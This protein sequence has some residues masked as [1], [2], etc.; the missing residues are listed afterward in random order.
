MEAGSEQ[1][2]IV[3]AD[4]K[5]DGGLRILGGGEAPLR[6]LEKGEF[7]DAGDF[8][9]C[10]TEACAKAEKSAGLRLE[11]LYYNLDDAKIESVRPGGSRILDG[12]GEIQPADVRAAVHAAERI[13]GDF[14]KK[15]VYSTEIDYVIDGQDP[16]ADPVGIFGHKLDV[17]VHLLLARAGRWDVWDRLIRRA[18][19]RKS[20]AVLS[21][22]SSAYGVLSPEERRGKRI[23]WDA[24]KDY[25]NGLV[26]EDGRILEYRTLLRGSNGWEQLSGVVPALCQEFQKK[27]P[28]VSE[29][30]LTGESSGDERLAAE[31]KE[32]LDIPVRAVAPSG[33]EKLTDPRHASLAGLLKLAGEIE[34]KKMT[35]RPEKS[36]IASARAKVQSFLSD[37]F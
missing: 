7:T 14:E 26:M 17:K 25:L 30:V 36:T 32:E 9:E 15:I 18:G 3:I 2:V 20:A 37:Y 28:G 23:L 22:L 24:A 34:G 4:K 12:E 29:V 16:V 31:L 6:G 11:K 21:G 8:V 19:Y 1:V 27:H 13:A 35:L 5:D 10:V 33:I